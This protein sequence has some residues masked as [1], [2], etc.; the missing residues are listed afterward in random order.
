MQFMGNVHCGGPVI[1]TQF[2]YSQ[3]LE[4][5]VPCGGSIAGAIYFAS[6]LIDFVGCVGVRVHSGRVRARPLIRRFR[7]R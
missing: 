7:C 1:S 3:S 4:S 5:R 6:M 2:F